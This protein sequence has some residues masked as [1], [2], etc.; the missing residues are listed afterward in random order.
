M[1]Y[2]QQ[3]LEHAQEY[4]K[5]LGLD[6]RLIH[7]PRTKMQADELYDIQL[8]CHINYSSDYFMAKSDDTGEPYR[9]TTK[10]N[11]AIDTLKKRFPEGTITINNWLWNGEYSQSGLRTAKSKYYNAYSMHSMG[12]AAD[13]KF[14]E[15]STDEVRNDILNNIDEYP[16]LRGLELETSTWIHVD[17]RNE[18]ILIAFKP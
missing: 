15:Y 7:I 6:T 13:L 18:D 9:E 14:S 5:K 3:L 1:K 16:Y 2:T 4:C 10:V 11:K 17:C 8:D 12:K